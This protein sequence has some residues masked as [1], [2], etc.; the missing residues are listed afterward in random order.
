[1]RSRLLALALLVGITSGCATDR[2]VVDGPSTAWPT[3]QEI[4]A[5]GVVRVAMSA[6]KSLTPYVA[7]PNDPLNK[8]FTHDAIVT[9]TG[10]NDDGTPTFKPAPGRDML[11]HHLSAPGDNLGDPQRRWVEII[12]FPS[13]CVECLDRG[14]VSND[15]FGY[16]IWQPRN[17]GKWVQLNRQAA[18]ASQPWYCTLLYESLDFLWKLI[19]VVVDTAP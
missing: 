16:S 13:N 10:L 15:Q 4:L 11:V 19:P 7:P 18:L 17:D 5:D 2:F 1:M 6:L 14:T 12:D 9:L 8:Q 3:E